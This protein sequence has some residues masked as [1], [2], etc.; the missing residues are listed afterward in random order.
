MRSYSFFTIILLCT[1]ILLV[2]F[3]AFYWL[4][5]ITSLIEGPKL[6]TAIHI[7]FWFFTLG[8]IAAIIILKIRLDYIGPY[9]KQV[10]ISSLYGLTISSIIAEDY[11]CFGYFCS[12]PY[13]LCFFKGRISY[14]H[15]GNWS[16]FWVFTIFCYYIRY[17]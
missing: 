14:Y 9:R 11:F 6:R 17:F 3:F 15:S 7:L 4:Q 13:K 2:D 12:I 16:S 5:S 8:L 1:A 10:L